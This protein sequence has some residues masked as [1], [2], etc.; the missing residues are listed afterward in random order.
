MGKIP[1]QQAVWARYVILC[2]PLVLAG[3]TAPIGPASRSAAVDAEA[4][5]LLPISAILAQA[6]DGPNTA[7]LTDIG[8][9]ARADA[10][11]ARA[12][13]LRG[14]VLPDETRTRMLSSGPDLR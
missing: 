1:G 9:D 12:E 8:P 4:P 10:L 2:V 3:C 7:R 6:A 11:R 14:P 13:A 5:R